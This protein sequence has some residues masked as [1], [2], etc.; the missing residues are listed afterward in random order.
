MTD[1]DDDH[2]AES[3]G[4]TPEP[5]QTPP[6]P[7]YSGPICQFCGKPVNRDAVV[8]ISCGRQ[9]RPLQPAGEPPSD[10]GWVVMVILSIIAAFIPCVGA[11][12]GVSS[13]FMEGKRLSGFILIVISIV[14]WSIYSSYLSAHGLISYPMRTNLQ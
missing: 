3:N 2:N 13:L 1:I 5:G 8:C 4:E 6:V 11:V 9:I 10:W 14:S 7:V 12:I